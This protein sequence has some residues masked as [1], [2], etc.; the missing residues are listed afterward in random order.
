MTATED[1]IRRLTAE[2]DEARTCFR[3]ADIAAAD[4][5]R[6]ARAARKTADRMKAERDRA[7][8]ALKVRRAQTDALHRAASDEQ[9]ALSMP[10]TGVPWGVDRHGG[11]TVYAGDVLIG[12]FDTRALAARAVADH[13]AALS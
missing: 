9:D 4:W 2:R 11:R 1:T 13:N 3:L 5:E 6:E 8:T 10:Y 7:L 12:K